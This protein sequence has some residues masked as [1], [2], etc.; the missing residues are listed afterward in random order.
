MYSVVLTTYDDDYKNFFV[1]PIL[2]KLTKRISLQLEKTVQ[3]D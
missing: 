1:A 2:P 3:K